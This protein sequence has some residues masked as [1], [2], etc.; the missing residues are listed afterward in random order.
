[1]DVGK[2]VIK[3]RLMTKNH[4]DD[5][6]LYSTAREERLKVGISQRLW[7]KVVQ[8]SS[9]SAEGNEVVKGGTDSF[10]TDFEEHFQ[11]DVGTSFL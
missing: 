8:L 3:I 1:M 2:I 4:V 6:H 5:C 9:G 11:L 10:T 7:N